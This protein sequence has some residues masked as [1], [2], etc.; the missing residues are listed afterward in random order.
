MIDH[1]TPPMTTL[2]EPIVQVLIQEIASGRYPAGATLP[3]ELELA[4]THG[5]SRTAAREVMQK[6][7]TLGLIEIRR[8]KGATVLSNQDWNLLDPVVLNT[9]IQHVTD[10]SFYRSL[11]E[12]RFAVEPRAAELAARRAEEKDLVH[13]GKALEMM[14]LEANG[15]RGEGWPDADLSFHAAIIEASGNWVFKQLIVTVKAALEASIRLT[16]SRHSSADASLQQHRDVY[17]AIR[18]RQPTEAQA[19]MTWLLHSTQ[20]D[21]DELERNWHSLPQADRPH[22]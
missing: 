14:E 12:A 1:P 5:I 2:H 10:F 11:L 13:I 21:F 8:R 15:T 20:R 22:G 7:R 9:A 16:G 19:A 3:T 6:L 18:R 17:D 4:Q